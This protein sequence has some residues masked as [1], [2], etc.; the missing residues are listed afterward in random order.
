MVNFS[1]YYQ[2]HAY[3]HDTALIIA[4]REGHFEIVEYLIDEG[5]LIDAAD[6]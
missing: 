1:I 4:A 2:S 5:A 6:E 3:D